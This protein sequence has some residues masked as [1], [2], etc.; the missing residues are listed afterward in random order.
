MTRAA[1]GMASLVAMIGQPPDP[2]NRIVLS[3]QSDRFGTPLA[4]VKHR[5]DDATKV[6]WAHCVAEGLAVMKAAGAIDVWHGPFNA[7]HLLG[8]TLMG[9]DPAT[10]VVDADCRCH[11]IDNLVVAGSGVFPMSGGVSPT[12]TLTALARRSAERLLQ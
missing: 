3:A 5:L 1:R 12:F 9:R 7:G 8:G 11:G 4:K 2:G 6:L 10:S